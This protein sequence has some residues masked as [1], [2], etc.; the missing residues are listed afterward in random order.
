MAK[1]QRTRWLAR[2]RYRNGEFVR[3]GIVNNLRNPRDP[4]DVIRLQ[5]KWV[6]ETDIDWT[7]RLDEAMSLVSVLSHVIGVRLTDV[8]WEANWRRKR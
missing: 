5:T 6:P 8:E 1:R 7:M 3:A 2:T 4:G